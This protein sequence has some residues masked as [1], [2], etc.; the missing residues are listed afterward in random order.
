MTR[1]PSL[2][3]V[4]QELRED[5]SASLEEC[6]QGLRERHPDVPPWKLDYALKRSLIERDDGICRTKD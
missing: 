6:L 1:H 3:I 4:S 5:C 2:D